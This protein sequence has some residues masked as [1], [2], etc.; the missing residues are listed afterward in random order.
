MKRRK[1][2]H[3]SGNSSVFSQSSPPAIPLSSLNRRRRRFLCRLCVWRRLAS[4]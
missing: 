2:K 1:K 3:L 4:S